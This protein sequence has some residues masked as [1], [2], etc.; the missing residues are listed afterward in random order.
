MGLEGGEWR[1]FIF[2]N[3]MIRPWFP[4]KF[5][6]PRGLNEGGSKMFSPRQRFS[7]LCWR[8]TIRDSCYQRAHELADQ[9]TVKAIIVTSKCSGQGY[10]YV[11]KKRVLIKYD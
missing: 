6:N 4:N 7:Y 3:S 9:N 1:H 8:Q 2:M 10:E 5:E 11:G